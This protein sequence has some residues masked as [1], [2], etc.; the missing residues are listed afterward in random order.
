VDEDE[1]FPD[2][3]PYFT[4]T[5]TCDHTPNEHGWGGCNVDDCKCEAGWE[6]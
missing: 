4:G 1:E 5:C 3:E 2:Y 6:E